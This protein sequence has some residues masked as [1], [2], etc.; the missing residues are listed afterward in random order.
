MDRRD[1]LLRFFGDSTERERLDVFFLLGGGV[2]EVDRS[3]LEERDSE[4]L[5]ADFGMVE[6]VVVFGSGWK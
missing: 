6:A 2:G 1:D 5:M 3:V 4:R